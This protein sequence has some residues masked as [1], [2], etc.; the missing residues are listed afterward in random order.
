VPTIAAGGL[1]GAGALSPQAERKKTLNA[2][3]LISIF[4]LPR[5]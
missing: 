5:L 3:I 2:K 1:A 4:N